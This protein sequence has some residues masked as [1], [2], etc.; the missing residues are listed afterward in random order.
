M[1]IN[2]NSLRNSYF[3][4]LTSLTLLIAGSANADPSIS[5]VS[6]RQRW[7]W[8]SLVDVDFSV[9]GAAAG[10]AYAVSVSGTATIGGKDATFSA[11]TFATEP[12]AKAGANRVVW[13]FGADY[14]ETKVDD[15]LVTVT[16][17]PFSD[18]TPLY[19]VVDVSGGTSA[20]K[21]PFHYTTTAPVH[22]AGVEDPCKTTE[23][24]LKRVKAGTMTLGSGNGSSNPKKYPSHTCTLTEDYYLG[25]FPVTQ[26]QCRNIYG[27]YCSMFTNGLYRATRPVDSIRP[28]YIIYP[29]F[30][31]S[32]PTASPNATTVLGRLKARTGL[33]FMIPT[34]WQW[35]YACRA[36]SSAEQYSGAQYRCSSNSNPPDDYEWKGEQ[37]MWSADYGTSYVDQYPPNPW[38]FYSMLGN[39]WERCLNR[40]A[41]VTKD[42]VLTDPLGPSGT[43]DS[44]RSRPAMG[45]AWTWGADYAAST[46]SYTTDPWNYGGWQWI[47]GF[48]LC[49]TVK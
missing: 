1:N 9:D 15:L 42:S 7:P 25:I 31:S 30:D 6:A 20:A 10:E 38:G 11:R 48:R 32:N 34:E 47:F 14:P 16:A 12:I 43:G 39:V 23:I 24:W 18:T 4:L 49:V 8:N 36:G 37:G 40:G 26:A 28:D 13:D 17:T 44:T 19:L 29:Y 41:S 35:E 27:S 33:Q 3:V 2:R 5:N 46:V 21:W 45:G 22:T